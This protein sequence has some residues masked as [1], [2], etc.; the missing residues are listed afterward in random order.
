MT[1]N[2]ISYNIATNLGEELLRACFENLDYAEYLIFNNNNNNNNSN[3]NNNVDLNWKDSNGN[4]ILHILSYRGHTRA[5]HLM[6]EGGAD[7]N[8]RNSNGETPLH[9]ATKTKNLNAISGKN[10]FYQIIYLSFLYL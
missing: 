2:S 10:I 3:N 8:V 5:L 1:T 4:S 6:L 9:W 7:P